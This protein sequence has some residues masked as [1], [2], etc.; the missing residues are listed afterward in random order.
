MSIDNIQLTGFICQNLFTNCLI[1]ESPENNSNQELNKVKIN[2][3][4]GNQNHVVFVINNK[5]HKYLN[6]NEMKFLS[7]LLS[8]CK[9]SMEDIS[10][11]NFYQNKNIGYENITEQFQ[12]KTILIFGVSTSELGLPFTIPFFQVQKFQE[13]TY[14]T[15]PSLD[16]FLENIPLKKQLWNSLK[17]VFQL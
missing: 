7:D 10:L 11:V 6:D 9:L 5:E 12:S 13:Q 2:S 8:A 14:L 17:I 15:A 16:N 1:S 3:L 4:G